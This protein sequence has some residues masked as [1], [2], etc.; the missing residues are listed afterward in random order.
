MKNTMNDAAGI[1]RIIK[2][3]KARFRIP[4]NLNFYSRKDFI[5]AERKFLKFAIIN[6]G[7]EPKPPEDSP[8]GQVT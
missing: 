4:E 6:G 5:V 7:F 8:G 3:Y 2:T 1:Q